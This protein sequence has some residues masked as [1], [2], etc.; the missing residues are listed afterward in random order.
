MTVPVTAAWAVGAEKNDHSATYVALGIVGGPE[1]RGIESVSHELHAIDAQ[2]SLP[3]GVPRKS[4]AIAVLERAGF[5]ADSHSHR[6]SA[7]SLDAEHANRLKV[8]APVAGR[9]DAPRLQVLPNVLGRQ[10]K[11]LAEHAAALELIRGNVAKPLSELL[12]ADRRESSRARDAQGCNAYGSQNQGGRATGCGVHS[13]PTIAACHAGRLQVRL[14]ARESVSQRVS[15]RSLP[16]WFPAVLSIQEIVDWLSVCSS[17]TFPTP[18]L[19]PIFATTSEAW[20]RRRRSCSRL[21]GKRAGR[22]GSPSSSSLNGRRPKQRFN[23]S[24]DRCSTD[25]RW[26]SARHVR[27][28]IGAPAV[29]DLAVFRVR[30]RVRR[31]VHGL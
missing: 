2:R 4:D 17:A 9:L 11:A 19:K 3:T 18:P 8:T 22:A 31:R 20:H 16:P 25:G 13:I 21:T 23:D 14:P 1:L 12:G 5:P 10:T 7:R 29:H 27:A 6:R 24:T 15:S 28:K 26:P 30:G